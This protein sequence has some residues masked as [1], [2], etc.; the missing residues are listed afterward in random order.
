M[1]ETIP[2][3][4]WTALPNG[5]VDFVNQHWEQATGLSTEKTLGSAW[6]AAIHPKT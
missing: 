1:I 6:E 4:V 5:A 2:T 3:I